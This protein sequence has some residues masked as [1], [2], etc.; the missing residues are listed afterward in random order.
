MPDSI[1][2]VKQQGVSKELSEPIPETDIF[3]GMR[4]IKSVAGDLGNQ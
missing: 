1:A 3:E 4:G 2:K